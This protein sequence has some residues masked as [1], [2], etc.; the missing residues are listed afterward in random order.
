MKDGALLLVVGILASVFAWGLWHYSGEYG[1]LVVMAIS[2][3]SLLVDN[4]RL[5]KALRQANRTDG[6]ER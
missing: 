6:R 3:I 1:A 5:R 2:V 4:R